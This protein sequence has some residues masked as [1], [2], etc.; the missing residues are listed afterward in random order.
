MADNRIIITNLPQC[1]SEFLEGNRWANR[2]QELFCS[3]SSDSCHDTD[4]FTFFV[5]FEFSGGGWNLPTDV[6]NA[7]LVHCGVW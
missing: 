1:L 7:R 3:F 2:F 4:W 6:L 5:S